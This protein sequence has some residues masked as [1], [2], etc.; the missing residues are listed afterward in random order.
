MQQ[1]EPTEPQIGLKLRQIRKSRK[2]TLEDLADQTGFT[3]SY[4][5]KIENSKKTP[6]IGSLAKI[7]SALDTE[8]AE[9]FNEGDEG[10]RP[11]FSGKRYC[12][13]RAE[14]RH[15]VVRGGTSFGY[16]YKSLAHRLPHKHMDP[17]LFTFPE[18][19][20]TEIQFEHEGEE[21]IFIISGRVRFFL[22]GEELILEPGDSVYFD[23]TLRHR[24]EA[25][26]GEAK[27]LV[28]VYSPGRRG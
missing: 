14:E 22:D 16:D 10:A 26:S 17:F 15:T 2:M 21:F 20:G 6:P 1:S 18:R 27:A 11:A 9:L 23:S 19:L 8:I 7:C 4:L 25:V 13:V 3:K 12:V 24:G 5:S 28:V